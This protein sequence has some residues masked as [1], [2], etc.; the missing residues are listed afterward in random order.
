MKF[1]E[2]MSKRKDIEGKIQ[3]KQTAWNAKFQALRTEAE[4]D[5]KVLNEELLKL[6]EVA[7]DTY[8]VCPSKPISFE[9]QKKFIEY[10]VRNTV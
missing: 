6:D 9:G 8:G 1:E 10:V 5:A 3:E 2:Y 4:A 7:F